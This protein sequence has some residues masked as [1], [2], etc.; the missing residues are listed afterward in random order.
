MNGH[1]VSTAIHEYDTDLSPEVSHAHPPKDE[2]ISTLL[3]NVVTFAKALTKA[4]KGKRTKK[5]PKRRRVSSGEPRNARDTEKT[6]SAETDGDEEVVQSA[7]GQ[8]QIT[9]W[10]TEEE[11]HKGVG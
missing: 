5:T 1:Q 2:D 6:A 4:P 10:L 7:S 3:R 9:K 11:S 8:Q